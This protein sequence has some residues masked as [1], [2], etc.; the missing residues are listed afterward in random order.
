VALPENCPSG[1]CTIQNAF[2][3]VKWEAVEQDMANGRGGFK[4]TKLGK[5]VY[6]QLKRRGSPQPASFLHQSHNPQRQ[7]MHWGTPL[8]GESHSRRISDRDCLG[9][10]QIMDFFDVI[11]S[12]RSV[13]VFDSRPVEEE[14]LQSILK[15]ANDAPSAGNFQ[16]YEIYL[17]RSKKVQR[18]L[19][20]AAFGQLFIASAPLA[21]VFCAYPDR[22]EHQYGE[23]GR[24]LYAVQD[25][26]IACAYAMLAASALGLATVWIG[27]FND[28]EVQ[29]AIGEPEGQIPVVILPIGYGAENPAPTLRRSLE[30]LVHPV[31]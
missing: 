20:T 23:R 22:A 13:R 10:A 4:N 25:A 28:E 29:Q 12:R 19:A 27:A 6:R 3:A 15:A 16:S 21:L 5:N 7:K 1:K 18:A 31:E 14:K 2:Q 9:G 17:V 8:S 11:S 26:T 24:R 30:D